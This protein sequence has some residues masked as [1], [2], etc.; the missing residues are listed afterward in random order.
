M[1]N[2]LQELTSRLYN[3]GIEKARKEAAEILEKAR[4]EA[5]NIIQEAKQE[6]E[7]ILEQ[8]RKE[9]D[10]LRKNVSGEIKMSARQALSAVKQKVT[11]MIIA[12][13][14]S[15]PVKEAFSDRSFIKNIIETVIKNWNPQS[16][17][18]DLVLILPEEE[19]KLRD[20]FE[21]R[22][23][24][25]LKGGLTIEFDNKIG[26]GFR[27]GPGD[28]TYVL[29]FTEE[30]FENFFKEYLRP[31]TTKLLYGEEQ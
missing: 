4:K 11:D 27:I 10:D 22:T 21:S 12:Q 5:E 19:K 3:E 25:L 30:D 31:R 16:D 24:E 29:S 9:A 13:L 14:A 2:K 28:R 15:G 8:A 6:A 17:F 7:S 18:V 26:R 1:E 23:H 20:Y